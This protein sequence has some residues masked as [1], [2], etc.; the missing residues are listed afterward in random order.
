MKRSKTPEPCTPH[1]DKA[2]LPAIAYYCLQGHDTGDDDDYLAFLFKGADLNI[3]RRVFRWLQG[4]K[5]ML[6]Y[7]AFK[8]SL[9]TTPIT[10]TTSTDLYISVRIYNFDEQILSLDE[11]SVL[12][13]S[14]LQAE[15]GKEIKKTKTYQEFL[16]L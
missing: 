3:L 10:L 8:M 14:R 16:N 2:L 11:F 12:L 4:S 1:P 9:E 15:T 5:K 13:E 7:A 6:I